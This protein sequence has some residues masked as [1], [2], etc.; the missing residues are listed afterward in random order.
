M[1]RW[2]GLSG[3]QKSYLDYH[4][5][6]NLGGSSNGNPNLS[7]NQNSS[8]GSG[9]LAFVVLAIIALYLVQLVGTNIYKE[10][11]CVI[12]GCNRFRAE[13][14]LVC[15]EHAALLGKDYGSE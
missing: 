7:E 13:E 5:S 2:S 15:P 6:S 11:T 12:G 4:M 1:E 8:G 3:S 14:S 9:V 10:F